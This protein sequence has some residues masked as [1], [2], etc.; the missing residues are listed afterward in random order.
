MIRPSWIELLASSRM[1]VLA[2][3]AVAAGA[4]GLHRASAQG[5]LTEDGKHDFHNADERAVTVMPGLGGY[6]DSGIGC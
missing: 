5:T 1:R 6:P 2:P 3:L 4:A